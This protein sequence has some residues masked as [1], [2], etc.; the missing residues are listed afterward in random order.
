MSQLLRWL[1]SRLWASVNFFVAWLFQLIFFS[2]RVDP[3]PGLG[4]IENSLYYLNLALTV[5][6]HL[7]NHAEDEDWVDLVLIWA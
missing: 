7:L 1:I 3:D 6:V 4:G 2:L 5:D